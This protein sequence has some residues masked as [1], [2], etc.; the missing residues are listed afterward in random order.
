MNYG[1]FLEMK[2]NFSKKQ[3]QHLLDLLYLREWTAN[4]SKLGS[5]ELEN[6][7]TDKNTLNEK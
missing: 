1:G 6:W 3:Y 7:K 5:S 2:T 4:S